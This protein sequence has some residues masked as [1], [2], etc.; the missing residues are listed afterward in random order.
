MKKLEKLKEILEQINTVA[1]NN[2]AGLYS[3]EEMKVYDEPDSEDEGYDA[4][5]YGSTLI[6]N[7]S[8]EALELLKGKVES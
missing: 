7:L 6:F 2:P 4:I 8:H 5:A 3:E 1:A